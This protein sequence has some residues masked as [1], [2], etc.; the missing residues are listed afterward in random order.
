[1]K[2]DWEFY[3]ER[4]C[5]CYSDSEGNRPCDYGCMCDRC[6]YTSPSFE[7][8]KERVDKEVVQ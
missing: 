5:Q 4:V 8:W 1:M 6:Q 2:N 3:L 7:E